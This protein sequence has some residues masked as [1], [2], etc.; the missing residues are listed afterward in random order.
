MTDPYRT[1]DG[2]IS[3]ELADLRARVARVESKAKAPTRPRSRAVVSACIS[4]LLA[5][6]TGL[7]FEYHLEKFGYSLSVC[8]GIALIACAPLAISDEESETL[9]RLRGRAE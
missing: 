9:A 5:M 4:G 8:A 7:A 6:A 3:R 1:D 2:A